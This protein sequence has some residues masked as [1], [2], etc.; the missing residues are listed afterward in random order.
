MTTITSEIKLSNYPKFLGYF[1]GLTA[2]TFGMIFIDNMAIV[3]L[4]F[5]L[6]LYLAFYQPKL[7]VYFA[8]AA[9]VVKEMFVWRVLYP[10][11]NYGPGPLTLN[12]L[13]VVSNESQ[14]LAYLPR[15]IVITALARLIVIMIQRGPSALRIDRKLALVLLFFL[16][17]LL[18]SVA[19]MQLN[20]AAFYFFI[21]YL[22]P[23]VFFYYFRTAEFTR[24]E[25]SLL[26]GFIMFLSFE[27]QILFS[28]LQNIENITSGNFF[29]GDDAVGT[30]VFPR[31]VE[32]GFLL[33]FALLVFL[34]QFIAER[35]T[36]ALVKCLIA[37]YGNISISSV[38]FL[39]ILG[40]F[41]VGSIFYA[42]SLRVIRTKEFAI[43]LIGMA[44]LSAPVI[45]VVNNPDLYY[46]G[47]HAQNSIEETSKKE[48]WEIPKIYSFINLV[49]M[50]RDENKFAFGAGPGTFFSMTGGGDDK[51][52]V[53]K[54]NS[55]VVLK[56]SKKK[57]LSSSMRI[58]NSIVSIIGETGFQG[59]LCYMGFYLII[60]NLFFKAYTQARKNG[61][62]KPDIAYVGIAFSILVFLI[63]GLVRN[64]I[65]IVETNVP[66]MLMATIAFHFYML[67]DPN[68]QPA[69][70]VEGSVA[71]AR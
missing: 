45:Y 37:F 21:G 48:V 39:F 11:F 35:N 62:Q 67:Y 25:A 49:N 42:Y 34:Y 33:T 23:F 19:N 68:E 53:K 10:G 63:N 65:E 1:L 16:L 15:A 71:Q 40:A 24:K 27:M 9:L 6:C 14:S 69:A 17:S 59:F 8:V 2:M 47:Q 50:M 58:E 13:R 70:P 20:K 32:S 12:F 30:F 7:F 4:Q 51:P 5:V 52:L 60:C 36:A 41:V 61:V 64:C 44:L 38:L 43:A 66:L 55:Y 31:S 57:K 28:M 54:Y 56:R 29:F 18:S 3:A 22:A 26:F 46:D